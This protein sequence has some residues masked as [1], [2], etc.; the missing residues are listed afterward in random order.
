MNAN[1]P[2][3]LCNDDGG[4]VLWRDR[5]CRVVLADEADYPGFLR[6]ILGAHVKEMTD[7]ADVDRHALMDVVFACEGALREVV[8]PDKINLASLG[9]LVPHLHWHVIPRHVDDPHY[10]AAVWAVRQ[11]ERPHVAPEDLPKKLAAALS[12][13]LDRA[14]ESE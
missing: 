13:R 10:P 8:S 3:P 12:R 1:T 14:P 11:R 4:R 9:N 5:L 6:V 7:L 2:C